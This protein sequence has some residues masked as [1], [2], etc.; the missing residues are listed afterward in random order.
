[1][2]NSI[3]KRKAYSDA[4]EITKAAYSSSTSYSSDNVGDFLQRVYDKLVE[5]QD[6]A[7]K[8]AD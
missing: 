4:V 3:Q 8:D 1:M 5:L 7:D 6:D 2:A